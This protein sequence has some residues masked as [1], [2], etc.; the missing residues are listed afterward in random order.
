ML[1]LRFAVYVPRVPKDMNYDAL[2]HQQRS[3]KLLEQ[4]MATTNPV[5]LSHER[6]CHFGPLF[7][8]GVVGGSPVEESHR[9]H[10][11]QLAWPYPP[12]S[13]LRLPLSLPVSGDDPG[14]AFGQSRFP[15]QGSDPFLT[16]TMHSEG[17]EC[18]KKR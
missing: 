10:P 7:D 8:G 1:S 14:T 16:G 15:S 6:P 18:V 5:P 13:A 3:R 17:A 4:N 11:T 2:C 12:N 9:H